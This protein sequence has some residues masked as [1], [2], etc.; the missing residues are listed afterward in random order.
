MSKYKID[1]RWRLE[2]FIE[3][4][5]EKV[6][7]PE[8]HPLIAVS[9]GWA[10]GHLLY[11]HKTKKVYGLCLKEVTVTDDKYIEQCEGEWAKKQIPYNMNNIEAFEFL[12]KKGKL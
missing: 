12:A 3:D 2:K 5:L 7:S 10:N 8:G 11:N 4:N 1:F 9:N 6:Y